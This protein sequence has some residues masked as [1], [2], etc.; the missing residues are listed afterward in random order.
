MITRSMCTDY[1]RRIL[2]TALYKDTNTKWCSNISNGLDLYTEQKQPE[3]II[4]DLYHDCTTFKPN[5]K[6]NQADFTPKF[7]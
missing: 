7:T 2:C 3:F 1:T 6:I 4:A 5:G